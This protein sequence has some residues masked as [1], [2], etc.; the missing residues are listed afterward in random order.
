[1]SVEID[2]LGNELTRPK[3]IDV[4]FTREVDVTFDFQKER[5]A[6]TDAKPSD[7]ITA[8]FR[9]IAGLILLTS[10]PL[11]TVL[12]ID[13]PQPLWAVVGIPLGWFFRGVGGK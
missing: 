12:G 13:V 2:N 1:M 8:I 4:L 3:S 9:G 10:I 11:L 5:D 6:M 7:T